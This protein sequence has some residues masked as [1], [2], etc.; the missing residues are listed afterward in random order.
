MEFEK[1]FMPNAISMTVVCTLCIHI[2]FIVIQRTC[3]ILN[4]ESKMGNEAS[5][6]KRGENLWHRDECTL[7]DLHESGVW[8][9]H[10]NDFFCMA[11]IPLPKRNNEFK[12]GEN[13]TANCIHD[14]FELQ[15]IP[16]NT[17]T[18]HA[19]I[20]VAVTNRL[21][22]VVATRDMTSMLDVFILRFD[23]HIKDV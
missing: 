13:G 6:T 23:Y 2:H 3:D 16:M 11:R 12:F 20:V 21:D 14:A 10:K 17:Q 18:R 19:G 5:Q 1:W 7:L 22:V 9:K 15:T 8:C 4:L